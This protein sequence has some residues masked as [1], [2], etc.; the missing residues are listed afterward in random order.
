MPRRSPSWLGS[1]WPSAPGWASSRSCHAANE[2]RPALRDP[3]R[4][5]HFLGCLFIGGIEGMLFSLIPLRFLPGHRVRQWGWMPWVAAHGGRPLYLFVHVLLVPS[6]ATSVSSTAAST[7]TVTVALFVRIRRGVLPVLG[8]VPVPSGPGAARPTEW[9]H[10]RQVQQRGPARARWCRHDRGAG[11][12]DARPA[13]SVWPSQ[14]IVLSGCGDEPGTGHG[15]RRDLPGAEPGGDVRHRRS[16][17]AG[18]SCP[19]DQAL[20]E[21][22]TLRCTLGV[23]DAKVPYRVTLRDVH[24][25]EVRVDVS[26]GRRGAAGQDR[27]QRLRARAAAGGLLLRPGDRRVRHE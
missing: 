14:C 26:A 22:M 17:S 27:L 20:E 12:R 1:R 9:R 2:R 16:R 19:G 8:L 23:A 18:R 15:R 6:P 4:A 7:A 21:G 5:T 13:S 25:P 10:R 11:G 3:R 24:E